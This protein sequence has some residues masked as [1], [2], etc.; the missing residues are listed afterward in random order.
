[1]WAPRTWRLLFPYLD[2]L[3][4]CTWSYASYGICFD[5]NEKYPSWKVLSVLKVFWLPKI[6]SWKYLIIENM[7]YHHS[8]SL[9]H[10]MR[11]IACV[12]ISTLATSLMHVKNNM[13]HFCLSHLLSG[14]LEWRKWKKDQKHQIE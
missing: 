4:P 7:F 2:V 9:L 11:M 13:C 14:T 3:Q 12:H 6:V 10:L 5:D 1:M 8:I